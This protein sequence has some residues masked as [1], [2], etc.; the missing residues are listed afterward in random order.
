[1]PAG[2][3]LA[4]RRTSAVAA[5]GCWDSRFVDLT[6]SRKGPLLGSQAIPAGALLTTA[7]K[8]E[9]MYRCQHCGGE[10]R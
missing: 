10:T 7:T 3:P 2:F 6:M 9:V 8:D 4:R 1:M 5:A